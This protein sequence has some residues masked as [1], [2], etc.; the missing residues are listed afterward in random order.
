MATI[1]KDLGVVTAYA[2]AVAG[3]YT[4]TEAD[5]QALLGSVASDLAE[6][7]NLS[8]SVTTLPEGSSATASYSQG[9]LSLGIPRGD[10]GATGRGIV[11]IT[12]TS[13]SGLV[14][15]YTITYSSGDPT[16]FT[17][18]NGEKGDTG[19]TGATGNGIA[20]ITKTG[21]SGNV[22]TYTITMTNGQTS[23]FTVTNS[24][25]FSVAGK[26][27]AVTLDAGDVAY[28][29]S[30]TYSNGTVGD[31]LNQ[32]KSAFTELDTDVSQLSNTITY[33]DSIIRSGYFE[34]SNLISG[35]RGVSGNVS[36]NAKRCTTGQCFDL[37]AGDKII[38]TN[39]DSG[40][41]YA[42][43]GVNGTSYVYDSGWKT[44]DFGVTITNILAGTYF[45]N[46]ASASGDDNIAPSDLSTFSYKITPVIGIENE[47]DTIGNEIDNCV[48]K[49]LIG[50]N[51]GVL[52][53]VE[54]N[55]G[56]YITMSTK[57][58]ENVARQ[59]AIE[60][61]NGSKEYLDYVNFTANTSQRTIQIG[62]DN[63]KYIKQKESAG[64]PIQIEIGSEKTR[65]QKYEKGQAPISDEIIS[66]GQILINNSV[67]MV[68]GTYDE[69][70][71]KYVD[72]CHCRDIFIPA[73][74]GDVIEVLSASHDMLV[75]IVS[76][77]IAA[78]GVILQNTGWVRSVTMIAEYDG[79]Y[80]LL[81]KS[82]PQNFNGSYKIIPSYFTDTTESDDQ[83][84]T[85]ISTTIESVRSK[86]TEPCVVF[87][88]CTDIH[89][90]VSENGNPF[91]FEKTAE[92]MKKV[93]K[94]IRSDFVVCLGDLTEGDTANTQKYASTVSN[95]MRN[96]GVPYLLAI[97]NHDDNRYYSTPFTSADI[98]KYYNSFVDN[99]V[100][101][102]HDTNGRDYYIDIPA[103]N[104]RF[105]VLDSN[106]VGAYGFSSE[107]VSWFENMA[108]DTP[109]GCACVVFVH[110]SPVPEQNYNNA[111]ITNGTAIKD[112]I[113]AYK[114]S[115]KDIIQFYGH[116]HCDAAFTSPYLSIGTNCTKFENTNGDQSLW[117]TGATKPTRTLGNATED[118]WDM[119]IIRPAS[120]KVNC[121]RFG[122]GSDREYSF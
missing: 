2:Y 100:I 4:G 92:N 119:V 19:E 30:T 13:T 42:I 102:N 94:N 57:S 116:S 52:Y 14:D 8:V 82:E 32:L 85:E 27:G 87:A 26:I 66:K 98:Y 67:D 7:E 18:T 83:Y 68:N 41:K 86:Q 79:Y 46:I 12:K 50:E 54:L 47:I 117:P 5:F 111:S 95:L 103:Y 17:V 59:T 51:V 11:S 56:D 34:S 22:D 21:T 39:I 62:I 88:L 55:S 71:K 31:G 36:V 114:N 53:P 33:E 23:T 81:A 28:S 74:K 16:T 65:F 37:K 90:G 115:G 6:I 1:V 113:V 44:S 77:P 15:T 64:E 20:S 121:V 40:F 80:V 89:Y 122:A 9:V 58:G 45:I 118:C 70:Y 109:N 69:Y 76:D 3:G 43:A 24:N 120:K 78:N 48:N 112:A 107:T 104:M 25:V 105:V 97:G 91:L 61:Y 101:V 75:A 73:R 38:A 29:D 63:V 49:N 60:L 108:L 72:R 96:L 99:K 110:E 35:T 10:T 106:T 93:L 84:D